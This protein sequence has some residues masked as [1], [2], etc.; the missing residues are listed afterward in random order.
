MCSKS[1]SNNEKWSLRRLQHGFRSFSMITLYFKS[2]QCG[3][4]MAHAQTFLFQCCRLPFIETFWRLADSESKLLT[5]IRKVL[6]IVSTLCESWPVIRPHLS[7]CIIRNWMPNAS[8]IVVITTCQARMT[9]LITHRC[10]LRLKRTLL[11]SIATLSL[12]V[13]VTWLHTVN[14]TPTTTNCF[15]SFAIKNSPIKVT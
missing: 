11:A 7:S 9:R 6:R 15:A 3:L 10:V 8:V 2:W 1:E 4:N 13:K 5:V 12:P 14:Y